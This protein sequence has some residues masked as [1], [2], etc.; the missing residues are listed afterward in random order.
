MQ[1]FSSEWFLEHQKTLVGFA[2][3]S[4]GR[5]VLRLGHSSVGRHEVA[6]ILPNSVH[7]IGDD[8][9][10]RSEFRV[11]NKYAK[12]LYY[13]GKPLWEAMH[14]FDMNIANPFVPELNLG[15]DTTTA[16]PVGG[17]VS[18]CDAPVNRVSVNET[19]A[20][21]RA[22]DGNQGGLTSSTSDTQCG[23]K[24]STTTDQFSDLRRSI[25]NVDASAIPDTDTISAGEFDIVF[26]FKT[27]GLGSADPHI[28]G[29]SP[30][31]T[32]SV[33]AGEFDTVQ[34]TS[35]GSIAY[36]SVNTD[37]TTYNV[38]SFNASG[39]AWISKTGVT[40][41]GERISW[42]MLNS[43][44][45]TWAS[46]ADTRVQGIFADETG[47]TKDPKLVVTHAGGGGGTVLVDVIGCGIIPFPR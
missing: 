7:W 42:D 21:I 3:T 36:A 6:A 41:F 37:N 32:A 18:P 13:A 17:A 39:I 26:N 14:W 30:S 19:F 46:G 15:F 29:A 22:A 47:D 2:N 43:F 20:T 24:A 8:G 25:F 10:A 44:T 35:F 1:V 27:N 9:L 5:H 4:I 45:G 11:H 12:R 38:F 16:R 34:N 40:S 31:T 28:C 33:A 23:L